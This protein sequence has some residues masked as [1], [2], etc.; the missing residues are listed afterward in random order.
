MFFGSWYAIGRIVLIGI[1]AYAALIALLR[2]TRKRTLSKMNAF[3]L[4]VTVALGS[5]LATIVVSEDIELAEGVA[6][7][8][9]LVAL[10]FA[11][12]WTSVRS[13]RVRRW[14]KS[15]PR[16]LLVDGVLQENVM[17]E[18]RVTP[19]EVLAAIRGAGHDRFDRAALV[20]LETDG[21]L[22]VVSRDTGAPG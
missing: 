12:T 6:A 22:S 20:T 16:A 5:T 7:L 9:T 10:Q 3:D 19:D 21:S 1:C 11:V 8:A 14:I 15:E 4:I 17:R 13:A 2:I 18:E